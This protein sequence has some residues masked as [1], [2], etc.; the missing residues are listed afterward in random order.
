MRAPVHIIGAGVMG[1]LLAYQLRLLGI[2]YKIYD[3]GRSAALNSMPFVSL[4][5][6]ENG[7]SELGDLLVESYHAFQEFYL[8]EKPKGV[9]EV[10]HFVLYDDNN[11]NLTKRFGKAYSL[12]FGDKSFLGHQ[13]TS[14]LIEPQTFLS[15]LCPQDIVEKRFVG[16]LDLVALKGSHKF[17]CTSSLSSKLF[18]EEGSS[19]IVAGA[20]L[21]GKLDLGTKSFVISG[22]SGNLLY[23]QESQ[24]ICI[25]ATSEQSERCLP[26]I[27]KLELIKMNFT[28]YFPKILETKLS[29]SIG[30]RLKGKKRLPRFQRLTTGEYLIDSFYKN[31]YSLPFHFVKK[32]LQVLS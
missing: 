26:D 27:K 2:E 24:K 1:R 11:E 31:G 6:I 32:A 8:K 16:H 10:S 15:F 13:L 9:V 25:G 21:V 22:D 7:K 5:G 18:P 28:S 20:Y 19:K 14:Y 12:T 4:Y 3:G 29:L 23:Y 30:L 17:L